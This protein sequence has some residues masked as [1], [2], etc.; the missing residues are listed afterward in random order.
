MTVHVSLASG[1][2]SLSRT[3]K[4]ETG[5]LETQLMALLARLLAMARA[6]AAA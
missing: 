4:G 5:E 1:D 3:L 2:V 6:A